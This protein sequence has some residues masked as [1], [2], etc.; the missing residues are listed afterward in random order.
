M[1]A[2]PVAE[3]ELLSARVDLLRAK[4]AFAAQRG[5]DA[6]PLLLAAAER[7]RPFD[8]ALARETYLEALMAAMIV[9][10]LFA[11]EHASAA[12][13]AESARQAPPP[14]DPPTAVDLFLDGLVVRLTQGHTAAVPMLKL[15]VR[16][17]LEE[18]QAGTADPR[19]H[20]IT[21]RVLLDLFDQD[22]YDALNARQAELL[23]AAGELTVLPAALT[24][25]AGARVTSGDFTRAAE[26]LEQSDAISTATGA[27]PHRSIQ[28]YLAACRGNEQQAKQLA[29][30]TIQEATARGE[31]SEV[32][33]VLFSLA[34]LHNG[35]AQ[36]E[37]ALAACTSALEYD[38]VGM[39]GHLLNEMVEAAA[40][41][42]NMG[43]AATAAAQVD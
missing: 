8:P 22:T 34:V 28:T 4:I 9:G 31:G 42:G 24:T 21:L 7:L 2:V 26:L 18:E 10:R 13:I 33:V 23:R 27:P 32:T 11:G 30:T 20:D 36:Y 38:D 5:R 41:S 16:T 6:P 35:L 39:Y 17:Y 14:S 25:Y 15:A 29:Q 40:R 37:E 12:A 43:I 1:I 19:W 3:D